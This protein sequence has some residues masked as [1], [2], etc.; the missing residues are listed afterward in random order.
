MPAAV[1]WDMD[2]TLVDTEPYWIAAEME[3][4]EAH[5]G[6]WTHEDALGLVGNALLE[7]AEILQAHGVDLGATEI[8]DFLVRRVA[9]AVTLSVPWQ[10][11]ALE[12]LTD[13]ATAGV[14]CALVT[15]SYRMLTDALV[16][17]SPANAFGAIVA[18]DEVTFG[19]P[20]PEPFLRAAALLG[21]EVR[22]CVALEDSPP[23]IAS[24]LASGARTIGI[25][26]MVPVPPQPGLSR[27]GSLTTLTLADLGR[28]ASGQTL[29]RLT[30]TA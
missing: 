27:I 17:A 28:V 16:A 10:P 15:M 30:P 14:P 13:L 19:K 25:E 11:G 18:G 2:G 12:L 29:D 22:D 7:S 26:V 9:E 21:V 4:V 5:G 6:V 20:H 1:L 24:A 8:I 3:L 23:G